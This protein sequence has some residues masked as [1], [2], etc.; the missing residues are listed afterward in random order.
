MHTAKELRSDSF[1]L[2]I[3]GQPASLGDIF[4]GFEERDRL[5]V[6]VRQPGGALGASALI[7]ATI[8][9]FYDIQRSRSSDFFIY[10]DYYLFHVGQSH[11][12][13]GMLDIWPRHKEVVVPDE[14]E[15][16]LRAINDRGITRL[17]VVEGEPGTAD[18]ERQTRASAARI[19]TAL[20]YSPIGK[21]SNAD[22]TV[23]GNDVTESYVQAVL[24]KSPE[25][26]TEDAD[27]IRSTRQRLVNEGAV[28]ESYRRI[29][30]DTALDLLA[31]GR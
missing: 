24:E 3:D 17:L 10:P 6:V 7:L 25:I 13:H 21:M 11:G 8:T 1:R 4:P 23:A 19:L 18:V 30:L 9:A 26:D 27:R 14:P 31:S 5:G 22:V 2:A 12:H 20:A 16:L 15:E 28:V 29:D